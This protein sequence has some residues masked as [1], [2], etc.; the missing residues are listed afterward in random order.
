MQDIPFE[1][2]LTLCRKHSDKKM[3][4]GFNVS[5]IVSIYN[6]CDTISIFKLYNWFDFRV[7]LLLDWLPYQG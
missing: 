5:Q 7:S 2:V 1:R 3:K 6:P 4:V